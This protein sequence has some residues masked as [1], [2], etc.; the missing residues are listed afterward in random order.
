M[1]I[2]DVINNNDHYSPYCDRC[3]LPIPNCLYSRCLAVLAQKQN[4]RRFPSDFKWG[5]GSSSYQIEGA[6]N[7]GGEL[8][9]F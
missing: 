5:V 7:E 3:P 1:A 2:A 9:I 8:H 4:V 6:W